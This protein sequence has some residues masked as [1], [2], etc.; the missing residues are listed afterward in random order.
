MIFGAVP[1]DQAEGGILAHSLTL[2]GGR[3]RKGT[4]L[5]QAALE[6]LA[7]EGHEEVTVARLEDG[8]LDE[9]R[10]AA[11]IAAA[12][13]GR[14]E[15]LHVTEPFTGRVNLEATRP[16]VITLDRGLVDALNAIDPGITLATVPAFA[17]VAETSLVAT[18]KIIPYAVP[19]AAVARAEAL[20]G[21]A[22][23]IALHPL[24][25]REA[26]LILTRTPGF[27]QKLLDK[28]RRTVEAR[29]NGLGVA[30]SGVRT[31]DHTTEAVG[32]A[33]KD[34]SAPLVLVLG[35]SATSDAADVCPAGLVAA[36][37]RLERFGMPV[38]PGNLL[39]LGD[40][41]GRAVLGLP[42]CARSPALNG[43]DWVLERL[44]AR[45]PVTSGDIA[46]MGVGGLLKEIP[47]RPQPRA[48]RPLPEGPAPVDIIL[49][50]AGSARRMG[51]A[52]K[53]LEPVDGAPLLRLAAEQAVASGARRVLVML[54]PDASER[55]AALRGVDVDLVEVPDAAEGMAASLRRGVA[56]L[57]PDTGA[58]IVAL[59]DMPEVTAHAYDAL[60]STWRDDS[61]A[62]ICRATSGQGAPG[63][64]VLFGR[65]FFES[66][67]EL[68]GDR[69]ARDIL[70]EGESYLRDVVLPGEAA[71]C[72]L[73]TPEA[74]AAFR[75]RTGR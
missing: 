52:D 17:R 6:L 73:D 31:V 16:G 45:V 74:W 11:R 4:R 18:V 72:D 35:A 54:P 66:L 64:P 15:H 55:A 67:R 44:V 59:A 20:L 60:I 63:H 10:A 62:E 34:S 43:A 29:L 41:D 40:V 1:L 37:G 65:R 38:D 61:G 24:T 47:V 13:A 36:G 75:A 42:G 68:K 71:V 50:A 58:V 7:A 2:K 33:L 57:A 14:A 23:T 8:D 70:R 9:D 25:L 28:G 30:L 3:L 51:G 27:A 12:L 53:L 32:A 39:F 5:D 48:V 46:A 69:G 26:E 19:E 22:G 21:N 49:L 56:G